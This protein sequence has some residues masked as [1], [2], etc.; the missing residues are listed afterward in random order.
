MATRFRTVG[1]AQMAS[2]T[3]DIAANLAV[4]RD[5]IAQA[6]A[7]GVD[8]LVFP[9][10]SLVGH[11]GAEA[12]LDVAMSR[13]DPRL[14]EL[15]RAAGDMRIV[16]GFVEESA[17]A[18]FYNAAA[19]LQNGRLLYIH[20]KINLPSYGRLIET[21]YYAHGRF[22]DTHAM[23]EDWVMGLLICADLYNPAL[24]HLAFL[25]GATFLAAPIS[26]GREAVGDEF[27]NPWSW[28]TTIQ[29]YAMMYGAPL[30]M[31][32]RVGTEGDLS[33]WGGSRILDAHGRVLAQGGASEELITAQLDYAD[34]RRARAMLPT[35]RDSNLALVQR[36]TNRLIERLGVPDVVRDE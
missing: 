10:L 27:D 18:Q 24:V 13:S 1:A 16:V 23:D 15:S 17:G 34:T 29:F 26:S 3:G 6:A 22:V 35:V 4:H 19:V 12:L 33:F 36:E 2:A 14:L 8:V 30:V 11:Y 28:A 20:R 25:H 7:V 32:N 21:K 9:E 5:F 31:V